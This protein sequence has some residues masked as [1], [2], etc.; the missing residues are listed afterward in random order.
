[1]VAIGPFSILELTGKSSSPFNVSDAIQAPHF[2][3]KDVMDLFSQFASERQIKLD[4]RIPL[5]VFSMT[6]GY[7]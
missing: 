4:E 1:V 6:S 5:D 7:I 2:H 3:K